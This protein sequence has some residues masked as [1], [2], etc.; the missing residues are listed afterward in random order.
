MVASLIDKSLLQQTEHEGEETRLL[1][2]E[3]IREYGLECLESSGELEATHLAHATYYLGLAEEAAPHLHDAEEASVVARLEREQENLRAALGTLLEQAQAQAGTQKGARA[4]EQ[5][6]RLCVALYWFWYERGHVREGQIFLERALARGQGVAPRLR[7][8]AL[9]AAAELAGGL[10]EMERTE[11]LCEE[12]LSLYREVSDTAG[13]ASSLLLLGGMSRVRG[14]YGLARSRLEEAASLFGQLGDGWMQGRCQVELASI[15]TEQG[16]YERARALLEDNLQFCQQAG[17]QVDVHW[18][19]YLMA[20]LLFVQQADLGRA[21]RLAEQSLA[22]FQERGYPWHRAYMLTLLAQLR[23]LQGGVAQAE[24]WSEESVLLVQEVGEREGLIEPLLCLAHVAL[25][26]GD[27]A[28]AR[29]RYQEGLATLHEMGSE[30]FLAACLEGLAAL[31]AA[32]ATPHQ[33]ARLWGAAEVLRETIGAPMYPVH[34]ASFEQAIALARAQLGEQAFGAAWSEGRLM[35][36]Q[37]ALAAQEQGKTSPARSA[38]PLSPPA[39]KASAFPA[40][41]TARELEV[42]RLL[43]QGWTDAQIA[44]HLVISVRTVNHHT[45]SL[46]SKLGVSS[47][48]AATRAALEYH[49][50]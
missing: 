42:L 36:P 6:L 45:S 44:E 15:A 24:E 21:Q 7:A 14:H 25:A 5:A 48:A 16:Q 9:Y 8:R 4:L 2:L 37:Q 30:A 41:L 26:Q 1:L 10:N 22:F 13:M 43:A 35:T 38:G 29:R 31:S 19:R 46:Y 28:D 12:G 17:H 18:V 34:R 47:R 40:G 32:Q 23:L 39:P 3:T 27:L 49:V 50:L 20:R 11:R 33:A